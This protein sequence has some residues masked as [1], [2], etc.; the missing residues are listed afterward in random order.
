MRKSTIKSLEEK[1]TSL[2]HEYIKIRDKHTCQKCE[3]VVSGRSEQPS[4]VIPKSRSKYLR[5]DED[6]IKVLCG[7]C[8]IWWHNNP[9]MAGTW[10][11]EKF[12][13]R[14]EYIKKHENISLKK[15]LISTGTPLREW[16]NEWIWYYNDKLNNEQS[17]S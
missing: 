17:N 8:H 5:W 12:T 1:L 11:S 14:S 10:F 9:L 16:L 4:H 3:R 13:K 6:N 7:G 2:C 15:H